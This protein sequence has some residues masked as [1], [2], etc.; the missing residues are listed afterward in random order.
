M[1]GGGRGRARTSG[2][3][4]D[5][6]IAV[7]R[8][9]PSLSSA[10]ILVTGA[11]G[12]LGRELIDVLT[13]DEV[14]GL[15]HRALDVGDRHAVVAAVER[16][17]PSW[18]INAAAFNDV[19]GAEREVEQ[20]FKVNASGPGYLAGAAARV[21][22]GIVHISTDYVFDGRKGAPYVESDRPNP[23]SAYGRSKYEGELQVLGSEASACVL[24]TAWLYGRWGKNFVK[25]ILAAAEGGGP[26]KVVAD[27]VGSPTWTRHLANAISQLIRTPAR[28]L[29]HVANGGACS[30]FEF[31]R[32]IVWGRVEVLPITSAEAAR[33]APRPANS[34]LASERWEAAG[35]RPLPPW[36]AALAEF[37]REEK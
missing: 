7:S 16:V 21:G 23:L 22:A 30:R 14:H 1:P 36:S 9:T 11:G 17:R 2:S 19:D 32:A 13:G 8:E 3:T 26:L 24:R 4:T 35:L 10:R 33:P 37:L 34:S 31:A 18:I 20:A 6:I 12:Q 5:R 27:Q 15:D 25:A 29:F 28:G